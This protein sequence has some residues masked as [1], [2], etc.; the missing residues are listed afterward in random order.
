MIAVR[1]RPREGCP[2][3]F[4]SGQPHHDPGGCEIGLLRFQSIQVPRLRRGRQPP[5]PVALHCTDVRGLPGGR[6]LNEVT[7][8]GDPGARFIPGI[9]DVTFLLS[10]IFDDRDP[11]GPDSVLG[12]LRAHSAPVRFE[13][14]PRGTSVGSVRYSGSCWVASYRLHSRV[15]S[16]VEWAAA[17]QVDGTVGRDSF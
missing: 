6:S 9:E 1:D 12:P 8:L 16:R 4:L 11:G 17:L 2:F 5:G 13:Y 15:G 10:G 14:G 7:A 3:F